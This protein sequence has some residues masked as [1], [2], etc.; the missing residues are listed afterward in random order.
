[1]IHTIPWKSS[2]SESFQLDRH[3]DDL[4]TSRSCLSRRVSCVYDSPIARSLARRARRSRIRSTRARARRARMAPERRSRSRRRPRRTH[5]ATNARR[6]KSR[7]CSRPRRRSSR[8]ARASAR[9][10][11]RAWR[12]AGRRRER[13]GGARARASGDRRPSVECLKTRV[14]SSMRAFWFVSNVNATS[15]SNASALQG[16]LTSLRA[17]VAREEETQSDASGTSRRASEFE[18]ESRTRASVGCE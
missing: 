17:G 12:A 6:V 1:M 9:A 15:A 3:F 5:R 2:C 16:A 7:A 18:S 13:D 8:V 10:S 14:K 11:A 4:R